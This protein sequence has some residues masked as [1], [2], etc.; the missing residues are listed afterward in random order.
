ESM[1]GET[2]VIGVIVTLAAVAVAVV[3]AVLLFRRRGSG[4]GNLVPP[5]VDPGP[6][7]PEQA[8]DVN[9]DK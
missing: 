1:L 6:T 7:H 3:V 9:A 5:P 4:R 2:L 8:R